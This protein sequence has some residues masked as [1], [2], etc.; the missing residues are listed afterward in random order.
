MFET[1]A[2]YNK[3]REL[4]APTELIITKEDAPP[5][6]NCNNIIWEALK[7]YNDMPIVSK[8]VNPISIDR[9]PNIRPKGTTGIISGLTSIIP[10]KKFWNYYSFN[11]RLLLE[12]KYMINMYWSFI[13]KFFIYFMLMNVM[14]VNK[15]RYQGITWCFKSIYKVS[16][17]KF[18]IHYFKF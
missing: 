3:C 18:S 7:N 2:P 10:L 5:E 12:A 17:S 9:T 6:N 1:T 14:W 11:K 8:G 16:P 15:Y 13:A 4:T